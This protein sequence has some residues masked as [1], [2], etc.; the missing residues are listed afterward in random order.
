MSEIGNKKRGVIYAR[1][2]TE[3]QKKNGHS[4]PSQIRLLEEKM[5]NDGVEP[6]HSP[7]TDIESGRNFERKGL[8][9]LL[10]LAETRSIDYV[11]VYD[12]DRLGRDVVETPYLMYRLKE[13]GVIV[14]TMVAEYN[15][16]NP[17]DYLMVIVQSLPGDVESRKL[18]ERTQRGK[19]EKFKQGKWVGPVPFGYKKNAEGALDILPETRYIVIDIFETYKMTHDIKLTTQIVNDKYSAKIGRVSPNQIRTILGNPVYAGRPRYGRIQILEEIWAIVD[20]KLYDEVQTIIEGKAKKHRVKEKKRP[21]S[22]LCDLFSEFGGDNAMR[23]L[24]L[25]QPHCPRCDSHMVR[26]GSKLVE[27]LNLP[28]FICTEK[29]CRYQR[30]IPLGSELE[31][32]HKGLIRC[33]KCGVV[34]D[35]VKIETL[36]GPIEYTCKRCDASFQFIKKVS[37][38]QKSDPPTKADRSQSSN[39]EK[40]CNDSSFPIKEQKHEERKKKDSQT[41]KREENR[42]GR[43]TNLGKNK[44]LDDFK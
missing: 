9:E 7:I 39:D 19:C 41:S 42:K 26:N 27:G 32:F 2:S 20:T 40:N 11:Y 36:N 29:S 1:V 8:K 13:F 15:F 38:N 22:K 10:K 37:D 25:L 3:E 12:L 24:K 34:D 30:T 5:R 6:V 31:Q 28:N 16:E 35:F 21:L 4:L 17:Y 43:C 14:R 23:I 44:T 18:G 33:P